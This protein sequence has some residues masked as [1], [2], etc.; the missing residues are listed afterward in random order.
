MILASLPEKIN[1]PTKI[2]AQPLENL[3]TSL[4][5]F[6]TKLNH[7]REP[8]L[9]AGGLEPAVQSWFVVTSAVSLPYNLRDN[10][11]NNTMFENKKGTFFLILTITCDIIVVLLSSIYVVLLS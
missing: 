8:S 7:K 10:L 11:S 1:L 3:I 9:T 4:I 5:S 2:K 6:Q